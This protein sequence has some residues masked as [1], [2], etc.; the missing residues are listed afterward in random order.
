MVGGTSADVFEGDAGFDT[1]D[2]S[3]RTGTIIGTPGT[4][5]DDGTRREHDNIEA[6]VEQV[7]LPAASRA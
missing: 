6:D 2:Y 3:G 5:A 7:I 1:V 4:G